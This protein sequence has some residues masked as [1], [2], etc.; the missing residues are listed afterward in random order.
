VIDKE[1][2]V[3]AYLYDDS[4]PKQEE[5]SENSDI[6]VPDTGIFTKTEDASSTI[7]LGI[8]TALIVLV[9]MSRY[10][11]VRLFS[12]NVKFNKK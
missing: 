9:G 8:P 1:I 5:G 3:T 11:I 10:F 7:A 6:S 2:V 4:N 12:K